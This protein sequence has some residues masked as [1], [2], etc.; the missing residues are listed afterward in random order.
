[1]L[2]DIDRVTFIKDEDTVE[3]IKPGS[4]CQI[5]ELPNYAAFTLKPSDYP[6]NDVQGWEV[7]AS[8]NG[9]VQYTGEVRLIEEEV[10]MAYC[11]MDI[12]C[13]PPEG[14]NK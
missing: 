2:K 4:Y 13:W 1:M 14:D 8:Q 10:G 12:L 6:E 9:E 5:Q 7:V 11:C 3:E